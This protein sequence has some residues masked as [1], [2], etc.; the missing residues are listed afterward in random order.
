[1]QQPLLVSKRRFPS[2]FATCIPKLLS[3][4]H[5]LATAAIAHQEQPKKRFA[6]RPPHR[7]L[8]SPPH[9]RLFTSITVKMSP[10]QSATTQFYKGGSLDASSPSDTLEKILTTW[11][12]RTLEARHDYIQH[13][14]PLPERS[15]VNP[16]APVLTKE[17]RDA[18]LDPG[19]QGAV[20]REG[21]QKAFGRMC[22]FYGF[23]LD[24]GQVSFSTYSSRLLHSEAIRPRNA[25][26]LIFIVRAPSQKP[27]ISMNAHQT[28]GSRPSTTIISAL[29][30]SSAACVS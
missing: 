1:M 24:E 21:L 26:N 6:T 4:P 16:D 23:V 19:S 20:L 29:H 18:F 11:S 25:I 8:S 17:V 3:R 30:G 14:F 2:T 7:L 10:A 13:L 12:D 22:T 27:V 9:S 15:P 28:A 5:L